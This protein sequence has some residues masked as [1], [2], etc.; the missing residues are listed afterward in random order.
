M[1]E[2]L[3]LIKVRVKTNEAMFDI[4]DDAEKTENSETKENLDTGETK[5]E[6]GESQPTPVVP[7]ESPEIP[8]SDGKAVEILE[9]QISHVT[10]TQDEF[11]VRC[12][13]GCNEDDGLMVLCAI[14]KYWQHGLCF[15]IKEENEAPEHHV[16]D[17]CAD[18]DDPMKQ[19]TD[20]H[21]YKLTPIAIQTT[22]LW[23]RA[24]MAATESSRVIAPSLAKRLG[25]EVNIAHGLIDRLEKEGFVKNAG[26]GKKY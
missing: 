23:R 2:M 13:C 19:P 24:L 14:C 20:P 8:G 16:C 11:G 10:E 4:K 26:K 21:L 17:V 12:P 9:S 6:N 25:I 1:L 5:M 3:Q 15:C 7:T 18:R 22:C